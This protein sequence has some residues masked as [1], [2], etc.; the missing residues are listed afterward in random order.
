MF[1]NM[2]D[3]SQQSIL[4]SASGFTYYITPTV[5]KAPHFEYA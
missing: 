3:V 1:V 4:N 5:A 2:S